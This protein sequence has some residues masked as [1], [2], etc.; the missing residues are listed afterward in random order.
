MTVTKVRD[1]VS[2]LREAFK[3]AQSGTP[4]PVFLELPLDIL[5]PYHIVKKEMVSR[6]PPKNLFGKV[7]NWYL[8]SYL[9]NL[10]GGAFDKNL[11][12]DAITLDIPFPTKSQVSNAA[13]ILS[14]AKKPLII[15]GSQS[16]LPPV[17]A[18]R[19]RIAIEVR[20]FLFFFFFKNNRFI[21]HRI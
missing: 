19:L 21:S 7:I 2:K 16:V 1:I 9:Q 12:T 6:S 5:Y 4:G 8:N 14:K 13:E 15:L 3:E 10:F 20:V 11:E 17:G 18:N